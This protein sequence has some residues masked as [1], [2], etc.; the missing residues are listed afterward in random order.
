[1]NSPALV[2]DTAAN[3]A[4]RE[5]ITTTLGIGDGLA[6]DLVELAVDDFNSGGNGSFQTGWI[7]LTWRQR[8][9]LKSYSLNQIEVAVL[10]KLVSY[11]NIK[12]AAID[13]FSNP[14]T[15]RLRDFRL[16]VRI[17]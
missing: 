11:E 12:N 13:T 6:S 14:F 17:P 1:M 8:K 3:L 10:K 16:T 4:S 2:T 5:Y 9:A 7:S 15:G